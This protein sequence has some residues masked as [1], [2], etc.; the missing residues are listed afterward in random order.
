L[1]NVANESVAAMTVEKGESFE[2][3]EER[4][5]PGAFTL[6]LYGE[7][8]LA[9]CERFETALERL[10]SDAARE[11]VIDL[12]GLTFIDSSA[13]RAL[14]DARRRARED[15]LELNFTLPPEGQ[16]RKVLDLTGTDELFSVTDA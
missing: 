16:V 7:F 3:R 6:R 1:D 12:T 10:A 11:L 15:S 14:L 13:I 5:G 2:I 4:G 9:G 8:D